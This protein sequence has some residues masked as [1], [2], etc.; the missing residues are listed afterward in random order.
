MSKTVKIWLI[1]ASVLVVLGLVIFAGV[2]FAY[3]WDFS[4]LSTVTY[5]TNT[6][7]VSKDFDDISINMDTTDITFVPTDDGVCRVVCHELEKVKHSVAVKDGLLTISTIDTRKWYDHIGIYLGTLKMTVYLPNDKYNDISIETD[8][9]DVLIPKDFAFDTLE[10][11]GDTADI[12][13]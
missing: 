3:D 13:C 11:A 4:K 5:K 6:Y 10:I 9:G 7:E 2:M 8:T 1:I 12:D